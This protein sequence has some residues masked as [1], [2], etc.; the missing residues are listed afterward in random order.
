MILT[1]TPAGVGAG[2]GEFLKAGD[3]VKVTIEGI[4]EL[5]NKMGDVSCGHEIFDLILRSLRS[6]AAI[7]KDGPKRD[8]AARLGQQKRGHPR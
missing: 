7:S 2:R 6:C 4:G 3:E 8:I 1:G 5:V